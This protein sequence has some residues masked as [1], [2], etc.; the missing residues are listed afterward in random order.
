M[1]KDKE[2]L[3]IPKQCGRGKPEEAVMNMKSYE[4][5]PKHNE[6]REKNKGNGKAEFTGRTLQNKWNQFS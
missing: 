6:L 4:I 2:F 1:P 5:L 3:I